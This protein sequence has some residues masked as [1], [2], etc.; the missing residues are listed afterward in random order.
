MRSLRRSRDIWLPGTVAATEDGGNHATVR[1]A[2][3]LTIEA[4]VSV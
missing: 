3:Q 1:R 2:G 4:T